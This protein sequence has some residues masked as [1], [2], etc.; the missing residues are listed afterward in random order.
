MKT[1]VPVASKK[2]AEVGVVKPT[3]LRKPPSSGSTYFAMIF[4]QSFAAATLYSTL[5]P[6]AALLASSALRCRVTISP[7]FP[8]N[9]GARLFQWSW[10]P[11]AFQPGSTSFHSP[12]VSGRFASPFWGASRTLGCLLLIQDVGIGD[13]QSK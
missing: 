4:D 3:L 8:L 13:F 6:R 7:S 1:S 9:L 12:A 10:R 5:H 11:A 2:V